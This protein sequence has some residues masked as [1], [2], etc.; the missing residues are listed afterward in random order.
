MN[1][2][3]RCLLT[4]LPLAAGL[5]PSA[6]H[7]DDKPGERVFLTYRADPSC[8]TRLAF[9]AQVEARTRRALWVRST[10]GVRRYGVLIEK[11]G[12]RFVGRL[13]IVSEEGASSREVPSALCSEVVEALALITALAI[14]PQAK[15]TAVAPPPKPPRPTPKPAPKPAP[16]PP[17]PPPVPQPV[18]EPVPPPPPAAEP[19]DSDA[20]WRVSL[21]AHAQALSGIGSAPAAALP[22]FV[23]LT[24][25]GD[26]WLAPSFRLAGIYTFEREQSVAQESVTPERPTQAIGRLDRFAGQLSACPVRARL[27]A[28]VLL[29]PCL[30]F[31]AGFIAASGGGLAQNFDARVLWLATNLAGRLQIYLH[32]LVA[33]EAE[34]GV[35]V[36]LT[37]PRFFFAPNVELFTFDPVYAFG[38][39]GL[40]LR[41]P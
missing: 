27:A 31:E 13:T 22:V 16:P 40:S 37:R 41:I 11:S 4:A 23:D 7:A 34:G 24:R 28:P 21:G 17:P 10:E 6:A 8:P 26:D 39:G 1:R 9:E 3:L 18:P 33:L 15:T 36:P 29:R 25:F 5:L 19:V 2:P 30:G 14:D 20:Q 12:A 32:D 38:G 35:G